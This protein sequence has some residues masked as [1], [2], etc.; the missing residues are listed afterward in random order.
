MIGTMKLRDL[1]HGLTVSDVP[2]LTVGALVLD[3]RNVNAGDV[4]VALSGKKSHGLTFL[5]QALAQ[6]AV[7]VLVDV[8]L[9]TT[10]V[11]VHPCAR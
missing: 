3:S 1:V 9:V 6:G 8:T 2:D 4:F 11:A 5:D 7:C 10:S